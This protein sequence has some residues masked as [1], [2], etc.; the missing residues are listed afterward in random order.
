[1]SLKKEEEKKFSEQEL[2]KLDEFVED[3]ISGLPDL[4]IDMSKEASEAEVDALLEKH[5]KS[6]EK[7]K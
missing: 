1:M 3:T 7:N 6:E 2:G 4:E 5:K